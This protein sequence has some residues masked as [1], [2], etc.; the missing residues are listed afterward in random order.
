MA[1]NF[2]RKLIKNHEGLRLKPYKDTKGI[3]TIGYG[4]N[5]EDVGI[6]IDEAR[7]LLEN[8][9]IRA[10]VALVNIFGLD[11]FKN[12]EKRIAALISMAFMGEAKLRG[13]KNMIAAIK[14]GDWSGAAREAEDSLWF[15]Q[16]GVRGPEVVALMKG[17]EP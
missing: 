9:L 14:S 7:Y 15:K 8:D 17:D 5:L 3:L 11:I 10:E 2:A 1:S 6:D 4:R 16:V 12:T 13:F